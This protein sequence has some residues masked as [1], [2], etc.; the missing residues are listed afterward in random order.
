VHCECTLAGPVIVESWRVGRH[1]PA[2]PRYSLRGA[3]S[4]LKDSAPHASIKIEKFLPS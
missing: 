2:A 4:A 3:R 1:Q